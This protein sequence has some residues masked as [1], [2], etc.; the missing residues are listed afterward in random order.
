MTGSVVNGSGIA[1][2][3]ME[4][5]LFYFWQDLSTWCTSELFNVSSDP[6]SENARSHATSYLSLYVARAVY[7]R[8]WDRR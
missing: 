2:S 3:V 1:C 6:V 8:S 7:K 5:R 4:I